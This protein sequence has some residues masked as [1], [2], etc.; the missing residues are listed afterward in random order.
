MTPPRLR[1]HGT[2]ALLFFA[3]HA[4]WHVTHGTA[5]DLLWACNVSMPVL[6]V[7]C[8]LP[9]AR[10][11]ASAV[12]ILSYG[13]PM[14]ILDLATGASMIPT[15][16][17]VH[18]AAPIVAVDAIRRLGWPKHTWA[19]ACGMTL[20]LLGVCRL[21]TPPPANVNL[22][23]RI[24]DGWERW[25]SSHPLYLAC[26]WT[27]S[28]LVFLLVDLAARAA[29]VRLRSSTRSGGSLGERH[30]VPRDGLDPRRSIP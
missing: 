3:A 28:A 15:S 22:A 30:P 27:G 5:W 8:L 24:H 7:G 14:W 16:P 29:L 20:A 4:T 17:L 13:T 25:F 6:V 21:V 18:V 9:S 19:V 26:M 23:F 10:L 11:C 2:L 12:L 1:I